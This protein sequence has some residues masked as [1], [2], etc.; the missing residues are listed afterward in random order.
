MDFIEEYGITEN[1]FRIL[2]IKGHK[3]EESSAPAKLVLL[4]KLSE[5]ESAKVYRLKLGSK[6]K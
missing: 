3:A 5:S 4:E 2:K 1:V 6:E